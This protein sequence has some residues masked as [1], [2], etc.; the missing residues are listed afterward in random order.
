MWAVWIGL[1]AIIEAFN[2]DDL[3]DLLAITAERLPAVFPIH[4]VSSGLTLVFLPLTIALRR[5][6]RWHRMSGRLTSLCVVIGAVTALIVAV[7]SI[8]PMLAR[9]GFFAQGLIWI[10]LLSA[11]LVMARRRR[12]SGHRRLML[13]MT[14]VTSGA[15]LFRL[16][17]AGFVFC[18][19]WA[20]YKPFYSAIAWLGWMLP[21]AVA[22]WVTRSQ[23]D[24]AARQFQDL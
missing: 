19:P 10:T 23:V 18:L 20:D 12:T 16:A 7:Y 11:G 1:A 8:S 21:F 2:L 6:P 24:R 17:L 14:A 22:A 9:V 5:W 15:V 3:P 13:M 4:M